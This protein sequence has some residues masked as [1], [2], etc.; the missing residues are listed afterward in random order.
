[1]QH[2]EALH[3]E[4]A[5]PGEQLDRDEAREPRVAREE[6]RAHPTLAELAQELVMVPAE[7]GGLVCNRSEGGGATTAVA[8]R[9]FRSRAPAAAQPASNV[10]P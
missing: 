8:A 4:A 9:P 1:M 5:E 2:Q 10:S 7:G 6:H 3:P